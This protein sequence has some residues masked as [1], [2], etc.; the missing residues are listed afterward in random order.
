MLEL[1]LRTFGMGFSPP[2]DDALTTSVAER[3]TRLHAAHNLKL[4]TLRVRPFEV[5]RQQQ[6]D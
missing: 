3:A 2:C 6:D 1:M 4:N 5:Y